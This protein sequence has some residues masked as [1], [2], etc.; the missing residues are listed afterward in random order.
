[1]KYKKLKYISFSYDQ[2]QIYNVVYRVY[3]DE[4]TY[5]KNYISVSDNYHLIG[6]REVFIPWVKKYDIDLEEMTEDDEEV[7]LFESMIDHG[8][9]L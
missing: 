6:I 1:M 3:G 4:P 7:F 2:G 5:S 8:K 9:I